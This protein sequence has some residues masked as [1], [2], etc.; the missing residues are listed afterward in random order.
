MHECGATGYHPP[1]C[2]PVL[3]HSESSPLGLSVHECGA[4]GSAGGQTA[5]PVRPKLCQSGAPHSHASPLCPGC[6]PLTGLD[7]CLFFIYLVLD[8]LAVRSS[9]S[10]GCARR[11]SVS[12]YTAILVLSEIINI[13]QNLKHG[14]SILDSAD[15]EY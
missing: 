3:R 13:K 10:S 9:V 12:T 2:L 11:R 15:R 1:L 6:A 4:A 7:E 8:F 5:C 14:P